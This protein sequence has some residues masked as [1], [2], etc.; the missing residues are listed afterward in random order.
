MPAGRVWTQSGQAAAISSGQLRKRLANRGNMKLNTK[1]SYHARRGQAVM[2]VTLMID[3]GWIRGEASQLF[4][5][6]GARPTGLMAAS[7]CNRFP[8]R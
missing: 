3:V 7:S 6:T 8:L 2:T 1:K 5:R 4:F